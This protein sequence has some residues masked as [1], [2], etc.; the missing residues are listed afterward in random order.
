MTAS[1]DAKVAVPQFIITGNKRVV[2]QGTYVSRDASWVCNRYFADQGS[3]GKYMGF[4][5]YNFNGL[6][7]LELTPVI[8]FR[9]N[10][11]VEYK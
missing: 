10:N 11:L 5:K 2:F 1:R 7:C 3:S 8:I 6:A 9:H 4:T